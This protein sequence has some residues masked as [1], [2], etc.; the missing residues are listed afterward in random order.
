MTIGDRT[1]PIASNGT[2]KTKP[3]TSSSSGFQLPFLVQQATRKPH[4]LKTLVLLLLYPAT[5]YL[6]NG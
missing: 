6:I 1:S 3:E 2:D 5:Q 4:V